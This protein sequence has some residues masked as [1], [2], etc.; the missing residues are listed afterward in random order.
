[1]HLLV[2]YGYIHFSKFCFMSLQV[3]NVRF[4]LARCGLRSWLDLLLQPSTFY[5]CRSRLWGERMHLQWKQSGLNIHACMHCIKVICNMLTNTT[6]EIKKPTICNAQHVPQY[7]FPVFIANILFPFY[8]LN[9]QSLAWIYFVN[10]QHM[11]LALH[12]KKHMLFFS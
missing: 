4:D 9:G 5:Q 8:S 7:R 12:S 11:V 3:G 1:M 6:Y 10:E 2:F